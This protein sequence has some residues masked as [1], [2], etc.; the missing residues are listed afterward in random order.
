MQDLLNRSTLLLD[1]LPI[2]KESALEAIIALIYYAG[3]FLGV[4]LANYFALHLFQK[5]IRNATLIPR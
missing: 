5:N 3:L 2:V 1:T 4:P